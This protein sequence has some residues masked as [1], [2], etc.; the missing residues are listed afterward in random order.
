MVKNFLPGRFYFSSSSFSIVCKVNS[1]MRYGVEL[2]HTNYS[3]SKHLHLP[4]HLDICIHLH[5]H[6]HTH[7]HSIDNLSVLKINEREE[8]VVKQHN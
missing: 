6:T 3:H 1:A 7:T 5:T 4:D 2:C 8:N